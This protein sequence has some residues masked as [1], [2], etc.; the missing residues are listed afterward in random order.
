MPGE[1]VCVREM[2][3]VEPSGGGGGDDRY[4]FVKSMA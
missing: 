3:V 1:C 4:T 2:V